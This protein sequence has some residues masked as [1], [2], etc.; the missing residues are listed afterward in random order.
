MTMFCKF[1]WDTP[2]N[3]DSMFDQGRLHHKCKF[4]DSSEHDQHECV[5]C[6]ETSP[7]MQVF[8]D[9]FVMLEGLRF[10]A[11][12]WPPPEFIRTNDVVFRC[13]N[14]SRITDEQRK[15][16]THVCRG[17]EYVH[18]VTSSANAVDVDLVPLEA[19]SLDQWLDRKRGL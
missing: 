14:Y 1:R 13:T 19:I 10:H 5:E 7:K 3:V 2:I 16:M 17:S 18:V 6:D 4:I 9:D 12:M 15:E 8:D 11:P